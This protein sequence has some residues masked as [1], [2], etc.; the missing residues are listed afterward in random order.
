MRRFSAAALGTVAVL[1]VAGTVMAVIVLPSLSDL[2]ST[3]YGRV[4]LVKVAIVA[5]VVAL[6]AYNRRW[7]VPAVARRVDGGAAAAPC[8]RGVDSSARYGSSSACCLRSSS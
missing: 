2:W 5:A 1:A 3:G 7:L 6:G 4:L 8:S